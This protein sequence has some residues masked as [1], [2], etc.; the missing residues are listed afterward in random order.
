M[1]GTPCMHFPRRCLKARSRN[2]S[3]QN[4]QPRLG[5]KGSMSFISDPNRLHIPTCHI[6]PREGLLYYGFSA[7]AFIGCQGKALGSQPQ[8]RSLQGEGNRLRGSCPAHSSLCW[9]C[10]AGA[11][12]T[13]SSFLLQPSSS[14]APSF[15]FRVN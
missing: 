7:P 11:K 13:L 14:R 4:F 1:T 12:R 5:S 10:S 9:C 3:R 15:V 2:T 6:L 8:A